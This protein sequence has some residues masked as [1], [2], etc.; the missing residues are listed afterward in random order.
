MKF[1]FRPQGREGNSSIITLRLLLPH[2]TLSLHAVYIDRS[3]TR[4]RLGSSHES[5]LGPFWVQ[6]RPI[7]VQ[8]CLNPIGPYFDVGSNTQER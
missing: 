1:V 7:T 6:S 3:R 2:C 8:S 5:I 4:P